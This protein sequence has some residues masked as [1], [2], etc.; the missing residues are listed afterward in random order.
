MFLGSFCVFIAVR[1]PLKP[2]GA[3]WRM[4]LKPEECSDIIVSHFARTE[5]LGAVGR[6]GVWLKLLRVLPMQGNGI[7]RCFLYKKEKCE[8]LAECSIYEHREKTISMEYQ[9][10]M[11]MT[12]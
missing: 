4:S 5:G 1:S 10:V 12:V 11:G 8:A 3:A 9:E 7:P 2:A 6:R